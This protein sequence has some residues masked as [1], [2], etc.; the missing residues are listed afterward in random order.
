MMKASPFC[1]FDFSVAEQLEV[2]KEELLM[3]K[4]KCFREN[5]LNFQL[6]QRKSYA[7]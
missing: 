1:S 4:L 2:D 3:Q 6:E 7:V 5:S